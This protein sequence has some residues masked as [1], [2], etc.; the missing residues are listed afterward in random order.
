MLKRSLMCFLS[1]S[2]LSL[3]VAQRSISISYTNLRS[4]IVVPNNYSPSTAVHRQ[5]Q[6][7]GRATGLDLSVNY[8]FPLP[9]LIKSKNILFHVGVGYFNERFIVKRPFNYYSTIDIIYYTRSYTYD[10]LQARLGISYNYRLN[11]KYFLTARLGYQA[12]SS[13]RQRYFPQSTPLERYPTEVHKQQ[14]DFG[15]MVT[16]AIGIN[17]YIGKRFSIGVD[18]TAPIFVR[19]RNDKIFGDDPTKF[20]MPRFSVGSTLTVRY[21]LKTKEE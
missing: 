10:N 9:A 16:G 6:F 8:S 17:R 5:N 7:S 4:T 21:H 19:W 20:F 2:S 13:F 11:K 14:M 1:M 12:F 18:A 3:A 15:S